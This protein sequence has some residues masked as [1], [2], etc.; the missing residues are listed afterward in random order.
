MHLSRTRQKTARTHCPPPSLQGMKILLTGASGLIGSA[1]AAH[2]AVRGHCVVRAGR[3]HHP[4]APGGGAACTPP[5]VAVDFAD[6]PPSSWWL[7]RL[8]GVDVVVNA[9]GIFQEDARQTF[10]AVH[11]LAPAA[12]FTAAARA[13]VPLVVQISALGADAQASTAFHQSKQRA[14]ALLRQLPVRSVIVQ[15]SL[16]YAPDGASAT[17]FNRLALLP[18]VALPSTTAPLQPVALH[19]LVEAVTRMVEHPPAQ[20]CTVPAVGPQ[21]MPLRT[22]LARLRS[23]L[24]A[25]RRQAVVGL[26]VRWVAAA[27]RGL[28]GLGVRPAFASPDALRMLAQGSSADP[29]AFT[30]W[31]ARP[32]TPVAGFL[33]GARER[34]RARADA[35]LQN[36]LAL[37]HAS[38][39]T[40]WIVTG[41]LSLGLYPVAHSVALL[42]DFGLRGAWAYAALYAGA[43]IDLALGMAMLLAPHRW[44]PAVWRAQLL[45]IA[46]YTLL[47]TLRMPHWWLHPFGPILKNL[48]LLVGIALLA[49]LPRRP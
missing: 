49:A 3:S 12:L 41:L 30:Q 11:T 10:D 35:R 45:V 1:L 26:P 19:D 37:M 34:E 25:R 20:S 4:P 14:D 32:P 6:P 38:V 31:L 15:P 2:W 16:V 48:P 33:R 43:G 13:G 21:A 44:R 28:H 42:A 27:V 8:H 36:L 23:A 18:V 39:A 17:L 9:A 47:I 24:G 40:V 46:G 29:A 7:P 22:Y 5:G